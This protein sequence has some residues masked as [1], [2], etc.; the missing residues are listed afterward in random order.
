MST[1]G[2]DHDDD[3]SARFDAV[4]G[5]LG[6]DL[7]RLTSDARRHGSRIRLRRRLLTATSAVAVA[8]VLGG[9]LALAPGRTETAGPATGETTA[10]ADAT[11]TPAP[12]PA[13]TQTP[14]PAPTSAPT[15]GDG[16]LVVPTG[17]RSPITGRATTVGLVDLVNQLA[18]GE[19]SAFGGQGQ[20]P[21][22]GRV[23]VAPQTYATFT[24]TP[25]SGGA[26]T[27]VRINV[28]N[29]FGPDEPDQQGRLFFSCRDDRVRCRVDRWDGMTV[30][31]Y[32]VHHGDAVDR[33]VDVFHRTS[34]LRV[35]V[36][37]TNASEF[38]KTDAAVRKAPPLSLEVLRT[39]ATSD[40]WG[41]T[42]P[43]EWAEAGTRL[44]PYLDYDTG[45]RS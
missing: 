31:S 15:R 8:A 23:E 42:L 6:L 20:P 30:V 17:V 38:E 21:A 25:S 4:V 41:V 40:V 27:P 26:G 34:Q 29:G 24:W 39:I 16:T 13:P 22:D 19:A 12:T 32:E 35:V 37:S 5:D 9:G 43:R 33:H 28:Q 1:P 3:L 45:R 11:P 14:A 2:T 18:D 7:D 10:P 36:A 44:S